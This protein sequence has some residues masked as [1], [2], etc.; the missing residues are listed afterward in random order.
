MDD[1]MV[2]LIVTE[3]LLSMRLGRA[4]NPKC[5]NSILIQSFSALQMS[6]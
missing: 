1:F 4:K 5:M 3:H 2:T 6:Q